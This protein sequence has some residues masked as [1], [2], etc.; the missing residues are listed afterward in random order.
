L[1]GRINYIVLI[2]FLLLN[3]AY[4]THIVGG[5][6]YYTCLGGDN[7]KITLKLY[8]DC[9]NGQAAFDSPAFIGIYDASNNL[10][11]TLAVNLLVLINYSPSSD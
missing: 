2:L 1:R 8:R 10:L 11:N 4:A 7:Y 3:K 9:F 6:I 5:E